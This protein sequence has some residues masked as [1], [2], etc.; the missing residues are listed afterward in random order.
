MAI[1][2]LYIYKKNYD[3]NT[4]DLEKILQAYYILDEINC[5]YEYT[6]ETNLKEM[7]VNLTLNIYRNQNERN[8]RKNLIDNISITKK[9]NKTD[10]FDN[11]W[12]TFYI[13]IKQDLINENTLYLKEILN[14]DVLPDEYKDLIT[15]NDI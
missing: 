15:F 4:V 8:N 10:D 1:I 6:G 12:T 9:I 7:F 11:L 13:Q 14:V 2:G 5:Y 3:I